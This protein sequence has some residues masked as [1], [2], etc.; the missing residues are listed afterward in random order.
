M[1]SMVSSIYWVYGTRIGVRD[2]GHRVSQQAFSLVVGYEDDGGS[3]SGYDLGLSS[4][5]T[6]TNGMEQET[7][8]H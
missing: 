7:S 2:S 4:C 3:R 1:V 8:S 5:I 6:N